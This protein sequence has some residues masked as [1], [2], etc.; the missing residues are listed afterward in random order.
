MKHLFLLA[1]VVACATMEARQEFPHTFTFDAPFE[2]VWSASVEV[3]ADLDLPLE[4]LD[5]DSGRIGTGWFDMESEN[6]YVDCGR[7]APGEL[8]YFS[9]RIGL[10]TWAEGEV[11]VVEMASTFRASMLDPATNYSVEVRC[12]S[13][14]RWESEIF[15]HL[16]ERIGRRQGP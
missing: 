16:E 13:T 7:Q 12:Y 2:D 5:K 8:S 11:V 4:I 10:E 6:D 1:F 14:G 9:G 15:T 3:L